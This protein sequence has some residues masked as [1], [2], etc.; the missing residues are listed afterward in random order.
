MAGINRRKFLVGAGAAVGTGLLARS[1]YASPGI[2]TS[3]YYVNGV[4]VHY[5]PAAS[6]CGRPP[7]VMVHGGAHAGWAFDRYATYLSSM[8]WDCHVLDWY[9]HGLSDALPLQTFITRSITAVST[10]IGLVVNQLGSGF[11]ATPDYILMGHSMGGLASL[12]T[13]QSLRPQALVMVAPVV[14]AEVNPPDI[15]LEVNMTEPFWVPPFE[16]TKPMFYATMSDAE[17]MTYYPLLQAESP[18]AVWEATRWTV[19]VSHLNQVRMPAMAVAAEV[20]FLTPASTISTLAGMMEDCRYVFWPGIGH[21]DLLLK[22]T[23]YLPVVQD[24]HQ[25]LLTVAGGS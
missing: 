6:P 19:S 24:I 1:G 15:L 12:Y 25:W 20:D 13:A 11:V 8:N 21:G 9:H 7:I 14:P 23:G 16:Q 4:A 10:E 17:A 22:E 18:Q 2:S 3:V 5:Y